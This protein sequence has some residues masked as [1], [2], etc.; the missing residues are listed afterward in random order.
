[1]DEENTPNK[2]DADRLADDALNP[3]RAPVSGT[4]QSAGGSSPSIPCEPSII[5]SCKVPSRTGCWR[6]PPEHVSM[7]PKY[8][9]RGTPSS[10]TTMH[11]LCPST[12]PMISPH[13]TPVEPLATDPRVLACDLSVPSVLYQGSLC[14]SLQRGC[15]PPTL[16]SW[17]SIVDVGATQSQTKSRQRTDNA[18]ASRQTDRRA[19]STT[20]QTAPHPYSGASLAQPSKQSGQFPHPS[21]QSISFTRSSPSTQS[22]AT[23]PGLRPC[24]HRMPGR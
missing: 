3:S 20:R 12:S 2:D 8:P 6:S 21:I 18:C 22:L 17:S 23:D 5:I 9:H 11:P 14:R 1:M 16:P 4:G 15:G 24:R 10:P 13:H 7:Y 19:R